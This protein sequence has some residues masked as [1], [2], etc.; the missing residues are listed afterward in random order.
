MK[1]ANLLNLIG[2]RYDKMV[3]R[4]NL[5]V[6][7]AGAGKVIAIISSPYD[8]R[9]QLVNHLLESYKGNKRIFTLSNKKISNFKNISCCSELGS[10]K[11][12]LIFIDEPEIWVK[13]L[14]DFIYLLLYNNNNILYTSNIMSKKYESFTDNFCIMSMDG[15]ELT[16]RLPKKTREKIMNLKD[17]HITKHG[18]F[19][20]PQQCIFMTDKNSNILSFSEGDNNDNNNL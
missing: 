11:D 15:W 17:V 12:A 2:G 5:D 14:P 20:D 16:N 6:I 19:L 10:I 7:G 13:Q 8:N 1:K 3:K 4:K 18:I 9:D